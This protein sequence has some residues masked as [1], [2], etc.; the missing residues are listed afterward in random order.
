MTTEGYNKGKDNP[1]YG[2]RGKDSPSYGRKH[3]EEELR[4]MSEGQRGERNRHWNGGV[5]KEH[6]SIM[7]KREYRLWRDAIFNRDNF[8]CQHCGKRGGNLE[9][10]HIKP[11]SEYPDLRFNIDNGVTLCLKCHRQ[12]DNFGWKLWNKQLGEERANRNN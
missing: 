8:T 2:K 7:N 9:A 4:K 3:T 12:T 10:H 11:F 6:L 5:T 1:M